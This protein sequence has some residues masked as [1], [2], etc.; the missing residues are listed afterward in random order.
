MGAADSGLHA[1]HCS[2][3][4]T[5]FGQPVTSVCPSGSSCAAVTPDFDHRKIGAHY[6]WDGSTSGG[7]AD[8]QGHGTHVIGSILGNNPAQAVDCETFTTPGGVTNLDGTAPGAQLI[9]Q[10]MG[11]G[12]QYL[13][14]LGGSIYHAAPVAYQNGARIHNNSWGSSCRNQAGFCIAGCQVEYRLTT[15]DADAAVWEFPELAV[16]VAA[17]NSGGLGGNA[18]CGPGADVGAAGNGKNVF[19]I[20]SNNRGTAGNN[21]SGF[22]SRGPTQDRR[23]KPDLTA[24]GASIV[25]ASRTACG[26]T[27]MGGTSMA[28]PTAAGLAALVREYLAR[29]FYPLGSEEAAFA[30]ADPSAAL[31]KAIM[32]N[33]AE[34]ITG[35]GTTGGAPSQSQGWGRVH[36]DNALYF[37]GDARRLWIEDGKTG[38]ETG[39]VQSYGLNVEAGQ[40]LIVTLTWHDAPA[41][42]NANPHSV[43]R[44]RLEVI[45]PAGE[46]WT[47]KLTPGGG[48]ANPNPFQASTAGDYDDANNVHQI[49]FDNPAAGFYEVRVRGI[50]VAV[51]PQPYAL[52]ATGDL[53]GIGDP[54]FLLSSAPS[55]LAVCRGDDAIFNIGVRSI[56]DF[57]DA[58][59]LSLS[60]GLPSGAASS[61]SIDTVTPADPPA[62]SVLTISNTGSVAAGSYSLEVSGQ[63]SGPDFDPVSK[64]INIGLRVDE[65]L[66]APALIT[67]ANEAADTSLTPTF[68]WSEQAGAVEYRIEIAIDAD[69]SVNIY[70][71]IVDTTSFVPGDELA[72]GTEYFWR[73]SGINLCGEGEWSETFSF[74][75]RLEP[76]AEFSAEFFSI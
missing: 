69:F 16:F 7:P 73:V 33:G 60:D 11:A 43:N 67:P 27:T 17:G 42:V 23:S 5:S 24:Q 15:R 6:K 57:D 53:L 44:L 51:G 26:T 40:P 28:T 9:S 49:R 46:T 34:E 38:L 75:T 18:G 12:L 8:N 66:D 29:G 2:F 3:S 76:V 35:T 20:G 10:E 55:Q 36:L 19:S 70:D 58:V 14:A 13:N 1:T 71:E 56:A 30:I 68:S 47:Q 25:S 4:D 32:I 48:L 52:A 72:T 37:D 63:S 31:I 59:T 41:E 21:M 61:F 64:S 54:D 45:T 22:S 62:L 39:E 50:Q 65:D 74:T